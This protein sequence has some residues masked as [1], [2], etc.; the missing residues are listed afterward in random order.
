MTPA[1]TPLASDR[2][3]ETVDDTLAEFKKAA[4]EFNRWQSSA[5]AGIP[6]FER[7]PDCYVHLH[8]GRSIEVG[9]RNPQNFCAIFKVRGGLVEEF[10]GHVSRRGSIDPLEPFRF[11]ADHIEQSVFIPVP[12]FIQDIKF[13]RGPAVIKRLQ[14]LDDCRRRIVNSDDFPPGLSLVVRLL[15]SDGESGFL[16]GCGNKL[17]DN[18]FDARPY[19]ANDFTGLDS[20]PVDLLVGHPADNDTLSSFGVILHS[21]SVELTI[22]HEVIL[23]LVEVLLGP[24]KLG[25]S[26]PGRVGCH[27][28]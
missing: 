11:D 20:V 23:E 10:S 19:L 4:E 25:Q 6:E 1:K 16:V 17:P 22:R 14:S 3:R 15:E 9:M 18:V 24:V 8:F 7:A 12:K 13:A 27:G 28:G 5:R 26:A 21:K 2:P